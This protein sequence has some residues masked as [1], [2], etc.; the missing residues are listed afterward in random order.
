MSV[1]AKPR[2]KVPDSVRV[3]ERVKEVVCATDL[4]YWFQNAV[5]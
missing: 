2:I 5:A 4:G 1:T 3:G